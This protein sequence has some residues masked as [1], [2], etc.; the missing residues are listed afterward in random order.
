M[1]ILRHDR[2]AEDLVFESR[3]AGR[4]GGDGRDVSNVSC[5]QQVAWGGGSE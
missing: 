1:D 5:A 4:A 3:L 2:G